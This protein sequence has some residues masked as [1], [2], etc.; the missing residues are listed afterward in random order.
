M[1]AKHGQDQAKP[2]S[3]SADNSTKLEVLKNLDS[4]CKGKDQK[5]HQI[6]VVA[7]LLGEDEALSSQITK[8]RKRSFSLPGASTSD[9]AGT[10]LSSSIYISP[11]DLVSM[12]N[13]TH[14]LPPEVAHNTRLD[15]I[16]LIRARTLSRLSESDQPSQECLQAWLKKEP[17]HYEAPPDTM[18]LDKA[19]IMDFVIK[20]Q[21]KKKKSKRGAKKSNT[22]SNTYVEEQPGE[23][24]KTKDDSV[25]LPLHQRDAPVKLEANNE[26]AL[27]AQKQVI[28]GKP[29]ADTE[30]KRKG[31]GKQW[32]T[33]ADALLES[34]A[35]NKDVALPSAQPSPT[36]KKAETVQTATEVPKTPEISGTGD[37]KASTPAPS[38]QVSHKRASSMKEKLPIIKEG[39]VQKGSIPKSSVLCVFTPK[40]TSTTSASTGWTPTSNTATQ[41]SPQSTAASA[42]STDHRKKLETT[43]TSQSITSSSSKT[44]S[45]H[46]HPSP[47]SFSSSNPDIRRPS[48]QGGRSITSQKPDGFFWQLDSH[49]FPCAKQNCE[50]RCNLWDGASV[51]CPR[52]GPYSETRYC[53]REHLLEDV[54]LHWAI[55]GELVFCH[56]CRDST[57]PKS[58]REG[59]PLVPCLHPYDTP[60]R[61]RQAV[62]LNMNTRAGDYFIFSDWVD[63]V[64]A[65][66]PDENLAL[67]CSSRV[68]YTVNF[69]DRVEKDRFR[70]VLAACLF[71]TIEAPNLTEYLYRLIRDHIRST[72]PTTQTATAT[73][74]HSICTLESSLKYQMYRELA[75]P[76]ITGERHACPTDW[77]GR[78]RR[79]CTDAVCRAEYHRFLG[80]LRGGGHEALV[81]ELEQMYWV[82]RAARVTH[83]TVRSVG[84]R[85]RGVGFADVAGEDCRAFCRGD[86]WDG[87]GS[88]EM[89]IEGV[90]A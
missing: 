49:G 32:V 68:I 44:I 78:N 35:S 56:P 50:K 53:T 40:S 61:H 9:T 20:K 65:G 82:L 3:K 33:A 39:Q 79:N 43:G 29:S 16:S 6:H 5:S 28:H 77:D 34:K 37:A 59:P 87:A 73:Q 62:H 14:P 18:A 10:I 4:E 46:A 74:T 41:L 23:L 48:T 8:F 30:N 13:Y 19:S 15:A 25:S 81:E 24:L 58:V 36:K 21:P 88:G 51:I 75:L 54:K 12:K 17:S 89:E 31:K 55:C 70:R 85:M 2:E 57:I 80:S 76:S 67:R 83:P 69:T 84:E 86:G 45:N 27:G 60:Q 26:R 71:V 52:C 42:P 38:Q 64:D 90:N 47:P 72:N 1:D 66:F 7:N 63:I 11:L 22:K